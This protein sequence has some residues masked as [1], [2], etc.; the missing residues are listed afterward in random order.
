[1]YLARKDPRILVGICEYQWIYS[2]YPG[3]IAQS[4]HMPVQ[5][6]CLQ[7]FETVQH[8]YGSQVDTSIRPKQSHQRFTEDQLRPRS[9]L[10]A[11]PVSFEGS[12][13]AH[14]SLLMVNFDSECSQ[15][16]RFS[17]RAAT[18][19]NALAP[20]ENFGGTSAHLPDR[21]QSGIESAH[22]RTLY[23]RTIYFDQIQPWGIQSHILQ[24]N[25]N[26]F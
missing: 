19:S 18:F 21:S 26:L 11:Q 7:S 17:F 10:A 2:S 14:Q 6:Q 9:T 5:H 4:T 15:P 3:D 1:M 8:N 25:S 23:S 13:L 22:F 24:S 20:Y 16:P 12:R